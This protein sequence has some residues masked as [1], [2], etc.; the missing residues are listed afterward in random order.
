MRRSECGTKTEL[1]GEWCRSTMPRTDR[2]LL[3]TVWVS[4]LSHCDPMDSQA[5]DKAAQDVRLFA[6]GTPSR[7]DTVNRLGMRERCHMDGYGKRVLVVDEYAGRRALLEAQLKQEGYAVQTACDGVAGADEMRKRH[8]EAII[9]D[10]RLPGFSGH[11]LAALCRI[12]RP[13]TPS[14]SFPKISSM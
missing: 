4:Q 13:D 9:A 8:F 2:P 5:P 6:R 12:A 1:S 10:G 14:F 3:R 7:P 11:K